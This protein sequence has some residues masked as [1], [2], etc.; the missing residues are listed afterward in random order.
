MGLRKFYVHIKSQFG[1]ILTRIQ[2]GICQYKE[3]YAKL[4]TNKCHF[5]GP[6]PSAIFGKIQSTKTY[7]H[8]YNDSRIRVKLENFEFAVFCHF[9]KCFEAERRR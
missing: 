6:S 4:N 9:L 5:S 2:N 8:S 3:K 7:T 1:Y